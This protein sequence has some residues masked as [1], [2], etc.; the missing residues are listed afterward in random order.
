MNTS[1]R[2]FMASLCVAVTAVL[3]SACGG[4][5]D[6]APA[7]GNRNVL[8]GIAATGAAISGGTVTLKCASGSTTSP[9][10]GANG[11]FQVDVS[12]AALPCL[13][14]VSYRDASNMIQE[15]H[16][17]ATS[18]GIV[19]ITPL[20]ELMVAAASGGAP[21]DAF[22]SSA[23]DFSGMVSRQAAALATVKTRL[24]NLGISTVSF[25]S[26]PY[27]DPFVAA[28]SNNAGDAVDRILDDIKAK[29]DAA[30]KGLGVL[31]T[32]VS[33]GQTNNTS[34]VPNTTSTTGGGG[35]TTTGGGGTTTTGGGTTT[36]STGAITVGQVRVFANTSLPSTISTT[37]GTLLDI[38]GSGFEDGFMAVTF[39]GG[40][41]STVQYLSP[42]RLQVKIPQGAA[43]GAITVR[44]TGNQA[45]AVSTYVVAV[46]DTLCGTTTVATMASAVVGT[47]TLDCTSRYSAQP[48]NSELIVW[49]GAQFMNPN[50]S[51]SLDG[52]TWTPATYIYQVLVGQNFYAS[53]PNFRQIAAS[54]SKAIALD[55]TQ[56][57]NRVQVVSYVPSMSPIATAWSVVSLPGTG[58]FEPNAV[59]YANGLFLVSTNDNKFL[60]S[61]DG[62]TW[63]TQNFSAGGSSFLTG[64]TLL[65]F[66]NGKYY[67]CGGA[68]VSNDGLTWTAVARVFRDAGAPT[69]I[70][71]YFT[72]LAHNGTNFHMLAGGF[73][74]T[75]TDAITWNKQGAPTGFTNPPSDIR[76]I[77]WIGDRYMGIASDP[78]NPRGLV[79]S[80][81]N[82]LAWTATTTDVAVN[83][84]AY[85][86]TLKRAVFGGITS[87]AGTRRLFVT[88]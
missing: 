30:G 51:T 25:P 61:I 22:A 16:S 77:N 75:S 83:S 64:T 33:Q 50:G 40:A 65:Y 63:A 18:P 19:N 11:A 48:Q 13:L 76:N 54:G 32:D 56:S 70:P 41:T 49:D 74:W 24:D 80:S 53:P 4:G 42:T 21:R 36:T 6:G 78:V 88:Q 35:T 14:K 3:L 9:V 47:G 79:I 62:V 72:S 31:T 59:N 8:S 12:N 73:V 82:G 84:I 1:F 43:N 85:S 46:I 66:L 44:H 27:K 60:T 38:S 81:T 52:Y 17:L 23:P 57:V 34:I 45:S 10:T 55:T 26:N 86:P 28:F 15:L 68:C 20:T 39:A 2:Q 71:S 67:S 87:G 29:L 5:S 7:A 58:T 69:T 37:V